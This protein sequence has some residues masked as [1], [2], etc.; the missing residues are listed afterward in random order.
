MVTNKSRGLCLVL[1]V[2][3]VM[4]LM[5]LAVVASSPPTSW[6]VVSDSTTVQVLGH[7]GKIKIWRTYDN[8]TNSMEVSLDRLSEIDSG[9]YV[10]QKSS[11]LASSDFEWS[12][13]SVETVDGVNV[14]AMT[15]SAKLTVGR[16]EVPF[17]MIVYLYDRD[18]GF[19]WN[20]QTFHIKRGHAKFTIHIE[21]WPFQSKENRL[22]LTLELK[23]K[24]HGVPAD[25]TTTHS[26][27]G[28]QKRYRFDGGGVF[29]VIDTCL[30][31]GHNASVHTDL[32]SQGVKSGMSLTFPWFGH[33]LCY[34]PAVGFVTISAATTT[35]SSS[36]LVLTVIIAALALFG[37][38]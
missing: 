18:A 13:P 10:V 31:D 36:A 28:K 25:T 12:A 27:D 11:N 21:S 23:S 1:T 16:A 24:G 14:T 4:A 17:G 20:N 35:V 30:V 3:G 37:I 15:L 19:I 29:D 38:L 34:D 5:P 7:S 33:D 32:Y 26:D 2:V 6:T 8:D 22:Q 9:D